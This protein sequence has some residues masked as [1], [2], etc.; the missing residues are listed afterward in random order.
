MLN[1]KV[2]IITG[3]TRG[4][5]YAIAK[6]F[7]ENNAKVIIFGSRKESVDKAITS[8][9]E[10]NFSYEVFGYYPNLIKESELKE[11]F[12]KINGK[13]GHIDILIN[14]AGISSKTKIDDYTEE[15]FDKISNLNIKSVYTCSKVSIPYLKESH[16]V[17]LNTSSMVSIYGQPSGVMYPASKYAVNG[18]TK[19]LARELAPYGIRVNA[20][21][22]GITNTD[23][24]KSLPKEL[25]E[26]LIKTIPLGRIGEPED[27]ANAFLFL[28]S[29]MAS[30]ISGVILSVDGLAR[31]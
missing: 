31:S 5:G 6:K 7:L 18:I 19:S 22:P 1:D 24:V 26:P 17:I 28:A 10:L 14:N 13:Y 11:I 4:I 21:A 15:E 8:L 25:I 16:G 30:Y 23:M 29:D 12:G 9:K 3:G 2:A 27:I 20:V